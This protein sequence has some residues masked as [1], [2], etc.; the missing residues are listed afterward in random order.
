[1]NAEAD[2]LL[3]DEFFGGVEN[4]ILKEI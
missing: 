1:M 4:K 3:I 2:I